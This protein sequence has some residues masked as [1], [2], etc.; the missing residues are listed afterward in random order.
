[1]L[2][3]PGEVV[4]GALVNAIAV[5]GRQVGKAASGLRKQD[6]ELAAV[7]WFEAFRLT[8]SLPDL[9]GLSPESADRLA[10]VLGGDEVRAALQELLAVR[11]T[12]APETDAPRAREAVRAALSTGCPDAAGFAGALAA[13]YDDQV[14]ALVARLEAEESPLLAQIRSEAFSSRMISILHAIERNTAARAG[15]SAVPVSGSQGVQTG[16]HNTQVNYYFLGEHPGV[17]GTAGRGGASAGRVDGVFVSYRRE[18]QP[19]RRAAGGSPD[20]SFRRG[21]GLH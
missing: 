12:D 21:A 15:N 10:V 19:F 2:I 17:R 1:M 7:R 18:E 4:T 13:Y 3:N 20:Q 8:G 6:E 16:D 9:P 5:V 11:L 14:C